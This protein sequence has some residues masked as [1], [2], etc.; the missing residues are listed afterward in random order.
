METSNCGHG[1]ARVINLSTWRAIVPR[2][3][4]GL[5][6]FPG[7]KAKPL[8]QISSQTVRGR[9]GPDNWTVMDGDDDEVSHLF[10]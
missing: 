4:N 8:P 9:S 3:L 7:H 10:V 5:H 2:P 6:P 1:F